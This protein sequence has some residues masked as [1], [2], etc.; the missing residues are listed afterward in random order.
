M[1]NHATNF[2][3]AQN[4]TIGKYGTDSMR[5][6]D[7]T[8]YDAFYFMYF[9]KLVATVITYLIDDVLDFYT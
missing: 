6:I 5:T 8:I 2:L 4:E 9:I 1:W 3:D 7:L